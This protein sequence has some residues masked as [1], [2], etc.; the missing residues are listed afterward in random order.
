MNQLSTS[1]LGCSLFETS[2]L[3]DVPIDRPEE[4]RRE[5]TRE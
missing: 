2:L 1:R 4:C 5:D 3:H